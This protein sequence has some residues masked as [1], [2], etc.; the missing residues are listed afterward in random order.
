MRKKN[1]FNWSNF[2][3]VFHICCWTSTVA[4]ICFWIYKY[5]LNKDLVVIDYKHYHETQQDFPPVLSL[6]FKNNFDRKA[7]KNIGTNET[8]Y[9][10]FLNGEYFDSNLLNFDFKNLTLDISN[11]LTRYWIGWRNGSVIYP[12]IDAN[13]KTFLFSTYS[14]FIWSE[15]FISCYGIKVIE[16]LD[17]EAYGIELKT[18]VF[19]SEIRPNLD[20][21]YTFLHYPNQILRSLETTKYAWDK[22]N[23]H[24]VYSMR[25]KITGME[26]MK[27]RAKKEKHCSETW[28]SYDDYVLNKHTEAVGCSAP[29]QDPSNRKEK[30]NNKKDISK[31]Y[32]TLKSDGY[33]LD[34]PCKVMGK[35]YFAYEESNVAKWK[36]AKPGHFWIS[37]RLIDPYFKEIIQTR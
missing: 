8:L 30:C 21:F 18:T 19:N 26:V 14:G 27:R 13:R 16:G 15:N 23:K 12:N 28:E 35:M 10:R 2:I 29:Y 34:P 9:L 11:Y 6:C 24:Y 3:L 5:S 37:L 4:M 33:G 25:F 31:A 1:Y 17:F 7:L 20:G 32:F 36:L 22:W